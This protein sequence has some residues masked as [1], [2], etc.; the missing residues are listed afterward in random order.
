MPE[1]Q[2]QNQPEL[3]EKMPEA[4]DPRI[5]DDEQQ[6]ERAPVSGEINQ[7]DDDEA[8]DIDD[9]LDDDLDDEVEPEP[10]AARQ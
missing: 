2:D 5:G 10:D 7:D 4:A 6:E 1:Q 9:D 3:E 8:D